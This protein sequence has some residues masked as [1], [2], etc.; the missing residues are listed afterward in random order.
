MGQ[1]PYINMTNGEGRIRQPF[2][3]VKP[4]LKIAPASSRSIRLED[5]PGQLQQYLFA[6][7]C[8]N[9]LDPRELDPF[10]F[11][12]SLSRVSVHG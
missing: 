3:V 9:L 6:R 12:W 2:T 4:F 11:P 5:A 10:E 8:F 1:R 7:L